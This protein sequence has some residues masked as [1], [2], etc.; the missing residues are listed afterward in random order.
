VANRTKTK[1]K[2][3]MTLYIVA[4]SEKEAIKAISQGFGYLTYL[5]ANNN[6]KFIQ[7]EKDISKVEDKFHI[8]EA[9]INVRKIS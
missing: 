3:A 7:A 8:Y 2:K 5:K 4:Q 6:L 9:S 1:R